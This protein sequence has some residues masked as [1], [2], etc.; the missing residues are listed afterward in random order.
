MGKI[1]TT[2][3]FIERLKEKHGDKYDYSKI[4]Y[5]GTKT[6]VLITCP[7]HGDF[8]MRPDKVKRSVCLCP[9]CGYEHASEGH[10]KQPTKTTEQ[11][12][13]DARKTHGDK[14]DYS[15]VE[16]V[17]AHEK[18]CIICPKHG[19]FLQE[20]CRHTSGQGCPKCGREKLIGKN[21]NTN[22]TT[23]EFIERG[24]KKHGD[25]YDYSKVEYKDRNTKVCI[26]CPIHGEFYVTPAVHLGS[27]NG[28]CKKC[29]D[30]KLRK[31]YTSNVE[32]FIK[33]AHQ[34]H[35]YKYNY[36]KVEYIDSLTKVCII[37]P[38]HGEFWQTPNN[39]V[40]NKCI[41]L[42]CAKEELSKRNTKTT[43]EFIREARQVHGDKYDYQKTKYVN[44]KVKVC[45]IC[46]KHG[47]FWTNPVHFLQGHG[48]PTCN[49]SKLEKYVGDFLCNY[50]INYERQKKFKWLKHKGKLSLDFYLS[51]YNVGIEC[52]GRQ[53]FSKVDFFETHNN[54]EY[55]KKLD[56]IK[57]ELCEKHGIKI[58]YYS[59]LGIEYPYK[60]Y[61]DLDELLK[62][63]K[64]HSYFETMKEVLCEVKT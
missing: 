53:H 24:R 29:R 11:F 55:R 43:E 36:S 17:T 31:K 8:L 10:K 20:A 27:N 1:L 19:E 54:F 60:V 26:I 39:H 34:I 58:F 12:I 9:K 35:G 30:E 33:K 56:R 63:I 40:G 2:D 15:K 25:K 64:E 28:G 4:K 14:Y 46:P 57:Y 62:E 44:S 18:V 3:E 5:N 21:K 50:G 6:K 47:E 41:C 13:K 59:N 32:E 16:Y 45:I 61:E 23:E 52:Q 38:K 22:L 51:Q 7:K 48:C 37:C 49:E 42:E